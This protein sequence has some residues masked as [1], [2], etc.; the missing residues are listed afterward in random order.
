MKKLYNQKCNS[1]YAKNVKYRKTISRIC[2][3]NFLN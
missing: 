2:K 3:F 1:E